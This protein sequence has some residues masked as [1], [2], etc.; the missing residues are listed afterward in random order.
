MNDIEKFEN[1]QTKIKLNPQ[2]F[3]ARR[4]LIMFCLDLG[5]EKAALSHIKSLLEIFPNDADL[6]YNLGI[7]YE[8]MKRLL[9][10]PAV[11]LFTFS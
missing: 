6:Y 7:V 10:F 3:Q 2:N 9:A 11:S 1:L 5:F 8:K 4:E